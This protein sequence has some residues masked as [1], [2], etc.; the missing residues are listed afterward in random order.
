MSIER[1][2]LKA[3]QASLRGTPPKFSQHASEVLAEFGYTEVQID[4]LVDQGV[5][6]RERRS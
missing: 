1:S 6:C 2:R 5:V 4:D 3:N